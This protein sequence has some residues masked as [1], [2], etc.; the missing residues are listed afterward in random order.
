[1]L[2]IKTP[3]LGINPKSYM[4]G[5][6][7]LEIAKYADKLAE[8]FDITITFSA[9]YVDLANLVKETQHLIITAQGMDGITVGRGMGAVLPESLVN[10]GVKGVTRVTQKVQ[11]VNGET[12]SVARVSSEVLKEPVNE[13]IVKGGKK[14]SYSGYGEAVTTAGE[15]GWPATCSSVSSPFG[16]RWG[17]LHDAIDIAGCGY[18]SNIFAAK[19]GIVV[20]SSYKYDNG[21][22]VTIDHGNGYYSL[23]AHMVS[24]SRRVKVGDYVVKGQV[25]GSMGR[26]GAATGVHLHYA[27]WRGFPY[28]GGRPLNPLAFY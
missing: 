24:G 20:Q 28:R 9:P 12:V 23:Y 18:G 22:F 7:L 4:Y 21:E 14:S 8:R 11:K 26:T 16:Y 13:I 2:K 5:D 1:M 3:I 19:D 25:I 6:R 15:W 27:I 17:T 10:I